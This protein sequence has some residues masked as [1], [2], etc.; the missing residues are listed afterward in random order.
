MQALG[1]FL[2]LDI[3]EK[4]AEARHP[5][6]RPFNEV[7]RKEEAKNLTKGAVGSFGG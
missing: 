2:G 7:V 4:E 6:K 5:I 1:N 3:M